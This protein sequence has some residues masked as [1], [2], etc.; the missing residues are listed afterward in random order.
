[1]KKLLL[2][3]TAV[4]LMEHRHRPNQPV[5]RLASSVA[6]GCLPQ[7]F[8][9]GMGLCATPVGSGPKFRKI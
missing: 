3:G 1:M 6:V 2:A 9:I 4:L 7:I 8:A 5:L